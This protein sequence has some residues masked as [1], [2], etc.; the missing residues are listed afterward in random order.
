MAVTAAPAPPLSVAGTWRA[1]RVPTVLDVIFSLKAALAVAIALLIGFSQNL[2]NPYWSAL[3]VYVLVGQPDAGAIRSKAI[4]RLVGTLVGGL[5]ALLIAS[6]FA[7]QLGGLLIASIVG[8]LLTYYPKTI[9]RTPSNYTWFS[10]PLTIAVV[11]VAQTPVPDTIFHFTATRVGEIC[12][13][14]LIV[15]LVDSIIAPRAATPAFLKLMTDWRDHASEWADSALAPDASQTLEARQKRRQGLHKLAGLLGPLDALGVQLPYDIT[16]MPPRRRDM[17]LIRL[18]I[19]HLVAHLASAN[20]WVEAA[21]RSRRGESEFE[22]L[23]QALRIWI[24]ERPEIAVK[25]TIDHAAKGEDLRIRLAAFDRHAARADDPDSL[26]QATTMLRLAELVDHWS[27]LDLLLHALASGQ[28]LPPALTAAAKRA[29]PQRSIDY[30]ISLIDV[31]PLALALSFCGALWYFTT[32][33]ASIPTM[34]FVFISLGFVIATPGSLQAAKGIFVWIAGTSVL[35]LLYQFVILPH[36]T[37]FPVLLGI[38]MLALIP[39]GLLAAMS[40]AG[41]LI[42][43]NGFAFLGLQGAYVADFPYTLELLFGSLAGCV[44]AVGALYICQYDRARLH[45]RRLAAG[46][47]RDLSDIA[48]STRLPDRD[49]LLS[50]SVDRMALYFA[51]VDALPEDDPLRREDLIDTFRMT[52]NLLRIREQERSV[53]MEAADA[54]RSLRAV[55]GEQF[56]PGRQ[57]DRVAALVLLEGA[58]NFGLEEPAGPARTEFLAGLIGLRLSLA[59][60]PAFPLVSQEQRHAI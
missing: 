25:A 54:S 49:R 43:A 8:I 9:D 18:T 17:R 39:L 26:L 21:R 23:T 14:I 38:L 31:V 4:F 2:E 29:W 47:R 57:P 45:A 42:L 46:L 7:S 53:S 5:A 12:L 56:A 3:T 24:R 27:K 37:A 60:S 58:Y 59:A 32:W 15:G 52:S 34:L 20:I 16:A 40:P 51:I 35:A 22:D 50:L 11:A 41:V 19:A 1:L 33:T 28:P 10:A 55:L 13:A 6:M 44:I 48:R 30:V 36:V